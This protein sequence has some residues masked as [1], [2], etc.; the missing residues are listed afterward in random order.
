M[1]NTGERERERL[2]E[3]EETKERVCKFFLWGTFIASVELLIII[4][5]SNSSCKEKIISDHELFSFF[6]FVCQK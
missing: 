1:Y 3:K 2:G 4:I 6:C 5:V